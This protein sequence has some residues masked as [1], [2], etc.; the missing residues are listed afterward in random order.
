MQYKNTVLAAAALASSASA[1][2]TA[3]EPWT[4]LT[5]TATYK[6]ALTVYSET[7][8]IAVVP[9][10]SSV[11]TL[12]AATA[13]DHAKRDVISQIGDGQIQAT[14]SATASPSKKTA[15]AISQISD[16]QIQATTST[17]APKKSAAAISQISDGQIQATTS[18]AAPKKW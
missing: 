16:G 9:I 5:P 3:S 4:T 12:S 17:A 7:F 8:G 18:T 13:T 6:G 14:T 11:S 2:V 15:A 1:A 10:T